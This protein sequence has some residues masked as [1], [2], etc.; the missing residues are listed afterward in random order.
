MLYI[1]KYNLSYKFYLYD[2]I[3]NVLQITMI[4]VF[5][6]K[7]R[8]VINGISCGDYNINPNSK[9]KIFFINPWKSNVKSI[10]LDHSSLGKFL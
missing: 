8:L 10:Q 6:I 4:S 2:N 9:V 5:S 7:K 1:E 3:W